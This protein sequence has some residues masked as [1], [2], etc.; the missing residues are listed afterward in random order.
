MSAIDSKH[1]I[2]GGNHM[3]LR[4][5]ISIITIMLT[6]VFMLSVSTVFAA[7][8]YTCSDCGYYCYFYD[9]CRGGLDPDPYSVMRTHSS[10]NGTCTYYE[11]YHDTM[12][13]CGHCHMVGDWDI[14]HHLCYEKGHEVC[15]GSFT[16]INRCPY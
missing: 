7:G 8:W 1:N 15:N 6:S 10:P 11:W 12:E 16:I 14:G 9:D 5:K 2:L 4:S 3:K 13:K